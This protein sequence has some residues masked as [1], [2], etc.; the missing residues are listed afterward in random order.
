[1]NDRTYPPLRPQPPLRPS[2]RRQSVWPLI[3]GIIV[4]A[5]LA[6]ILLVILLTRDNGGGAAATDAPSGSAAASAAPPT[7]SGSAPP[8][9]QAP[10]AAAPTPPPA[11]VAAP[12]GILPVGASV[13][14]TADSLRI[15]EAPATTSP[16][17]TSVSSGE[18][19]YLVT[20]PTA[21]GPVETGGFVW[22]LVH[23]APG[24][25][26]WPAAPPEGTLLTG[27]VAAG[28]A[29][30]SY[31]ALAPAGCPLGDVDISVLY[32]LTPWERLACLGDRQ[33]TVEGTFGCSGCGG[34]A[35]GSFTPDWL[36][37]PMFFNVLTPPRA[38]PVSVVE[39]LTLRVPPEI[40]QLSTEQAGSV[41]RVTAHFND[42][43]SVDC[44]VAPGEPGQER[45]ANDLAAEW[46]C[47]EQL[48]VDTWEAIGT[49]PDFVSG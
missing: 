49:D 26:D 37:Y 40:A 18:S 48:V 17:V 2:R 5:I 21:L 23:Y 43:R 24:F 22:Y 9:S 14:V 29:T 3:A 42:A 15:R 4:L 20:D 34:L 8:A 7:G 47:R 31:L 44:V 10:S 39:Q 6:A 25:H 41:L 1:V 27:W 36:A 30:E 33:I 19:L 38:I 16:I 32:T 46:Y 13:D 35:P 28:S 45:P 11:V 12:E